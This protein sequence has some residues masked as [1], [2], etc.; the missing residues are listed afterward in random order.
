M[1][2]WEVGVVVVGLVALVLTVLIHPDSARLGYVLTG[3]II[4]NMAVTVWN[5]FNYQAARLGSWCDERG[6]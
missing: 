6:A 1:R 4:I 2:K 5:G 3:V